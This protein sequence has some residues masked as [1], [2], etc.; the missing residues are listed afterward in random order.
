MSEI[1]HFK[2]FILY[3]GDV[4]TD[5]DHLHVKR[6]HL[7]HLVDHLYKSNQCETTQGVTST[8]YVTGNGW[9]ML[10]MMTPALA[11]LH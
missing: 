2:N 7:E 6:I 9:L 1:H 4:I 11:L 3:N 10:I 8:L 5:V